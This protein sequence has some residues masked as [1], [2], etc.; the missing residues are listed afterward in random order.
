MKKIKQINAILRNIT[1]KPLL[2][3][4]CGRDLFSMGRKRDSVISWSNG[5]LQL[6][7]SDL[8]RL[9]VHSICVNGKSPRCHDVTTPP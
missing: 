5:H 3:A 9:L 8:R 7:V 1:I 6:R 4:G 2:G